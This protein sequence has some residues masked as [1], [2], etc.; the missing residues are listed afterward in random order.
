M[1][2]RQFPFF[3]LLTVLWLVHPPDL[4]AAAPDRFLEVRDLRAEL[5]YYNPRQEAYLPWIEGNAVVA[6]SLHLLFAPGPQPEQSLVFDVAA[7]TS[8]Y[9]DKQLMRYFEFS[10]RVALSV[11]SLWQKHGNRQIGI[12]FYHPSGEFS[13][14]RIFIGTHLPPGPPTLNPLEAVARIRYDNQDYFKLGILIILGFYSILWKAFPRYFGD[15]FNVGH[16]FLNWRRKET[17]SMLTKEQFLLIMALAGLMSFF[18]WIYHLQS[19][20][21]RSLIWF[22]HPMLVWLQIWLGIFLLLALK[23]VLI[24]MASALFDIDEISYP[25]F[26]ESLILSQAFFSLSFVATAVIGIKYFGKIEIM[27]EYFGWAIAF[28]YFFRLFIMYFKIRMK[29]DVRFVHLFSYLCA[30]ELLPIIVGLKYLLNI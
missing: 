11:D 3:L 25:Y 29:V 22:S 1:R 26:F 21:L 20:A 10:E 17:P 30:T 23:Y 14:F 9:I 28:F 19:G 8:L 6:K 13:R 27:A 24:R 16:L 2:D 12:S 7:G 18:L 4:R 5:M 15:F